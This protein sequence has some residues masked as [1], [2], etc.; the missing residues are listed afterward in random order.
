MP[1]PATVTLIKAAG[2]AGSTTTTAADAGPPAPTTPAR[3][4]LADA[5]AAKA[6]ADA[7]LGRAAS[8]VNAASTLVA[9]EATARAELDDMTRRNAEA[10]T[11][12]IRG[13]GEG[14]PQI[15]EPFELRALQDGLNTAV[16]TASAARLALPDLQKRMDAARDAAV[17]AGRDVDHAMRAV[18]EDEATAIAGDIAALFDRATALRARLWGLGNHVQA[19]MVQSNALQSS[20]RRLLERA[21]PVEASAAAVNAQQDRWRDLADRLAA[22]PDATINPE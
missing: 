20:I 2:P 4:K 17:A 11:E 21:A 6:A 22:D 3:R 1:Q 9:Q 12:W 16:A 7:A 18:L 13:G 14:Q 15:V 8:A 10:V 19:R 5:I